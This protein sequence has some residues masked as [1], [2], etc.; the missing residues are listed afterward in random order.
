M[1]K[2]T[3][4]AKIIEV[5][6]IIGT[7][8]RW[9]DALI[10][11]ETAGTYDPFKNNPN[12]S[13]L[14]LIQII[15]SSAQEIGYL[16]SADA[17]KSNPDFDSQMDNVVLPYFLLWKKRLGISAYDTQQKLY[18]TVF[19]PSAVTWDINKEFPDSIKTVNPGINKP[20]D[21]INFVNARIKESAMH[22]PKALPLTGLTLLAIGA[23]L[24]LKNRRKS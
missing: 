1:S 10:N 21:Y 20:Q 23:I 22:F 6:T 19:Y 15:N 7:E 17:V 5:A 2:E 16:D 4:A 8:P 24:Y 18:M 12:S 3:N 13:A 11:F 9:L 14:G